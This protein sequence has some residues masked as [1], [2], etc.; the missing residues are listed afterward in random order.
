MARPKKYIQFSAT[1]DDLCFYQRNGK[2]YLREA[3]ALDRQVVLTDDRFEKTRQHANKMAI[4]AKIGSEIYKQLPA[5]MKA[6]WIYRSITGHAASLLYKGENP[7]HVKVILYDKY[8]DDPQSEVKES[9]TS[10][11]TSKNYRERKAN[12]MLRT[13][14]LE[15]WKKQGKRLSDFSLAWDDPR[16]FNADNRRHFNHIYEFLEER[17]SMLQYINIENAFGKRITP[18]QLNKLLS[19]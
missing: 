13:L 12:K 7:E 15:S 6:R 4:A 17:F 9:S 3:K 18:A 1:I 16:S 2:T 19:E 14:F 5:E 8:I 11:R 10:Y